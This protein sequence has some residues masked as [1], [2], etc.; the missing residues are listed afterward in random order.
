MDATEESKDGEEALSDAQGDTSD[1][2]DTGSELIEVGGSTQLGEKT[3]A[4]IRAMQAK[5]RVFMRIFARKAKGLQRILVARMQVRSV[6]NINLY[7]CHFLLTFSL[8][9]TYFLALLLAFF[10]HISPFSSPI[11]PP[12]TH[13]HTHRS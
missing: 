13:I 5:A 12:R 11:F 4:Q 1:I 9:F 7:G 10:P 3:A 2:N 6:F 8:F